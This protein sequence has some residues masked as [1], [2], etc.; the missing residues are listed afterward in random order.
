MFDLFANSAIR[1]ACRL[2]AQSISSSNTASRPENSSN[3]AAIERYLL[4]KDS[5]REFLVN[6]PQDDTPDCQPQKEDA[7]V[8]KQRQGIADS[9][10]IQTQGMP[11]V[12]Q[13]YFH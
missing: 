4:E 6:G 12:S 8:C 2:K 7:Q 10:G 11:H 5:Y 1:M 3:H 13:I 9:N